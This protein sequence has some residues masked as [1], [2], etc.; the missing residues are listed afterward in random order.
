MAHWRATLCGRLAYALGRKTERCRSRQRGERSP[1][2]SSLTQALPQCACAPPG[3]SR[4]QALRGARYTDVLAGTCSTL[5]AC[6]APA[7]RSDGG[8]RQC[9]SPQ[10][11]SPCPTP[12]SGPSDAERSPLMQRLAQTPTHATAP[13]PCPSRPSLSSADLVRCIAPCCWYL[14]C[15]PPASCPSGRAQLARRIS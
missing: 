14:P 9:R 15:L 8:R 1:G 3:Y 6:R 5:C 12:A 4:S 7:M 11:R 2:I 13:A 10:H